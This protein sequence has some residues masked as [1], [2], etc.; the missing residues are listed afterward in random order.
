MIEYDLKWWILASSFPEK[1]VDFIIKKILNLNSSTDFLNQI[2]FNQNIFDTYS[3]ST[4]SQPSS[5]P[6]TSTA[7]I[8]PSPGS[9]GWAKA[10]GCGW[11][12][13]GKKNY[14]RSIRKNVPTTKRITTVLLRVRACYRDIFRHDSS[15]FIRK[16]STQKGPW[17][18]SYANCIE[19]LENKLKPQVKF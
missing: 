19:K 14:F 10:A 6:A 7:P 13:T 9:W 16:I 17:N 3:R 4:R 11:R 2:G 5:T 15:C 18:K 1:D 12:N 8:C